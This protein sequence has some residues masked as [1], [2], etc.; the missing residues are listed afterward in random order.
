MPIGRRTGGA[1]R[2]LGICAGCSAAALLFVLTIL[3]LLTTAN[4]RAAVARFSRGDAPA[5]TVHDVPYA[6]L[7]NRTAGHY[8]LNPAVVA[9]VVAA[10]SG[11]N[12]R[13]RSR[14][15]AY[16]L[17]QILPT[18]WREA[19]V[20]PRCAPQTARLTSPPCMDD[21][22]A[23]LTVGVAYLRQ[24]VLRFDGNL[25]L[26]LAAYNAGAETVEEHRGVPPYPE[27]ARYVRQVAL[28]WVHLQEDG[29]LTPFWRGV[30]RS[31]DALERARAALTGGLGALA[32]PRVWAYARNAWTAAW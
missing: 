27:T 22:A 6:D 10:E 32:E 20:E 31:Y 16:G 25:L 26:A 29:T 4:V 17:M 13:A 7:I 11:F 14:R 5:R 2:W 15:G 28:A 23:N 3:Y 30:L 12:A 1:P 19:K 24:L 9:A 8:R 21:P 18:T